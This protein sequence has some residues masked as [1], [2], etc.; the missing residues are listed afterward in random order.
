M[1]P[2]SPA[3]LRRGWCP[4]TLRPM[5][6]G[7]G[8][9]VRLHPPGARLSPQ[10]LIAIAA[11]AVRF[12]NGLVEISARANMQLRGVSEATHPPLVA[13]LLQERLVDE[14]DG[15]G[16]QRLALTSPLLDAA[17]SEGH[18]AFGDHVDAA[19]LAQRIEAAGRELAGLPAK[20]SIVVDG[21]GLLA[22]DAISADLRLVGV[23]PGLVFIGLPHGLWSA[24]LEPEAALAAALSLLNGF[25]TLRQ[26]APD[27]R[28]LR[29]CTPSQ[30]AG[31]I[32]GPASEGPP[33]RPAP[34]RAGLVAAGGGRVAA[35]AALPFGRCD[36]SALSRLGEAALA[37]GTAAIAPTP[38]RG[39]ACLGLDEAGAQRWL[40]EAAEV[41]CAVS[42]DDPRL[43]VQA[44][45]GKPACLRAET[46]AMADAATLADALS[47]QLAGGLSLHVSGCIKGCAHPAAADLTLV[48]AGGLYDVVMAGGPRDE[49]IARLDLAAILARLRPGQD[50]H[51]RLSRR[52]GPAT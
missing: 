45:A 17:A 23:A 22:L 50:L 26:S 21:G 31:L 32:A 39:L 48:G 43:S 15:E 30:L 46:D 12:G 3:S 52:S 28:R 6:T 14:F 7:D 11:L 13:A 4:S 40:A 37:A 1:T 2:T 49:P 29:D 10:Q 16:P 24:P 8:W 34:Q 41:G 27:L 25:L 42:D 9:L 18:R 51:S 44:C 33:P 19:A 35:M 36:A 20:F 47:A 5:E 38:W